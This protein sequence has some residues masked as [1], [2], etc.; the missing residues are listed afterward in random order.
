[1]QNISS[2]Q[3]SSF[4]YFNARDNIV[5]WHVQYDGATFNNL[6][7]IYDIKNDVFLI[8]SGKTF[9][10]GCMF[11]G[12]PYCVSNLTGGAYKDDEGTTDNGQPIRIEYITKKFSF[13]DPKLI[14]QFWETRLWLATNPLARITQ[15]IYVD[16]ILVSTQ[17]IDAS[18]YVQLQPNGNA[19]LPMATFPIGD[20]SVWSLTP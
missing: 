16:N 2:D 5:K 17:L 12:D 15:E 3:T 4:A 14:T 19:T 8:D 9:Y 10:D 13:G 20:E 6:V 11:M 7:I 18:K 1:M